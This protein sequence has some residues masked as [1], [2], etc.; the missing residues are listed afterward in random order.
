MVGSGP[1]LQPRKSSPRRYLWLYIIVTITDYQG[2]LY[3]LYYWL[4]HPP[5]SPDEC[6]FPCG[7][8]AHQQHRRTTAELGIFQ[9]RTVET[10]EQVSL[11]KRSESFVVLILESFVHCAEIILPWKTSSQT[12]EG[13]S[14]PIESNSIIMSSNY[15]LPVHLI[16]LCKTGLCFAGLDRDIVSQSVQSLNCSV[17]SSVCCIRN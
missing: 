14:F 10:V 1:I 9:W 16:H 8:L 15:S 17:C 13:A 3:S 6:C 12:S 4:L 5:G 7:V 2:L 11:L